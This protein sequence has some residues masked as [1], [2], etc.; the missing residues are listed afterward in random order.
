MPAEQL[1]AF[2]M[3]RPF[4]ATL[5]LILLFAAVC[6]PTGSIF[7]LNVKAALFAAYSLWFAWFLATNSRHWPTAAEQ[8]FLGV[9]VSC[10][11]FWAIVAVYYG[12]ADVKQIFF[13][14]KDIATTVLIAWFSHFFLRRKLL[15]PESVVGWIVSAAV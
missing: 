3:P 10:L 12:E 6:L 4:A 14:M 11:C 15:R 2:S 13:E 1:N 8:A 5:L 7:G 9:F